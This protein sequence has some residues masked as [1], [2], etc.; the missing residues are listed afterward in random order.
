MSRRKNST[1]T[2]QNNYPIQVLERYKKVH[3]LDSAVY[4]PLKLKINCLDQPTENFIKIQHF[5]LCT[6][7]VKN[8]DFTVMLQE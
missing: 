7:N 4:R 5:A 1:Y 3:A 2:E 6:G 8:S